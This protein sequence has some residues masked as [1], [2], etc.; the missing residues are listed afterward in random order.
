MLAAR[1]RGSLPAWAGRRG[2]QGWIHPA[3]CDGP[4]LEQ[5][6]RWLTLP[7]L[8]SL[9]NHQHRHPSLAVGDSLNQPPVTL[10]RPLTAQEAADVA[11][12]GGEVG[13]ER[14]LRGGSQPTVLTGF[15]SLA[16][17]CSSAGQRGQRPK[18]PCSPASPAAVTNSHHGPRELRGVNAPK[19]WA[20]SAFL[21]VDYTSPR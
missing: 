6:S 11:A 14:P 3:L 8:S 19:G 21:S 9:Q 4:C 15:P 10:Q 1:S 13:G 18:A 2:L 20:L 17:S 7:A 5:G 12:G 16:P